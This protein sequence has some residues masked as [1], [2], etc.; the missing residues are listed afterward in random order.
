MK[1]YLA[2]AYTHKDKITVIGRVKRINRCASRIMEHDHIVFSP[3]SHSHYMAME[4]EMPTTFEFWVRQNHAFIE[5]CDAVVVLMLP[6]WK[7][8][9][10]VKDEVEFAKTLNKRVI[11]M[12]PR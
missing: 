4:N 10:G 3:I 8:S 12:M 7:D 2:S 9:K 6:G 1:I 5:W 11:Y